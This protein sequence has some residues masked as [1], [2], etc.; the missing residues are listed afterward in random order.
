MK[1]VGNY[2]K[3]IIRNKNDDLI[4]KQPHNSSRLYNLGHK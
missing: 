1:H 4:I 2:L 3:K